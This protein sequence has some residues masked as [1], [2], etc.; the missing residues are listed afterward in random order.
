MT[1]PVRSRRARAVVFAYHN[2]GVHCLYSLLAHDV[3]VALVVT[4]PDDPNENQWF[5]SVGELAKEHHLP[6]LYVEDAQ[7][8]QL[9][10][11]ILAIAPDFIF[12]FY[13]RRMLPTALLA[14]ATRGALNMHG[15][16]LP[17]YR[18]RA[19]VNWAVIHGETETGATLHY[20]T[21]KPDAGDIVGQERV[22]ILPDETAGEVFD[23]VTFAAQALMQRVLPDLLKGT[24][25]AQAQ[26]LSQG[27][28]FGGRRPEDGQIDWSADAH[29]IHNLVRGVAPPYPGAFTEVRGLHLRVLRTRLEPQSSPATD[30]PALYVQGDACFV[31][32]LQGGR[33]RLLDLEIDGKSANAAQFALR[34][35]S[36]RIALGSAP[37]DKANTIPSFIQ[38]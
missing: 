21:A 15:A 35:G 12:S 38:T 2:V 25:Q 3:E 33:L 23:K 22:T 31:D 8:A 26:D 16:L 29:T 19:P 27:S 36:E 7:S 32:C 9:R 17:K 11:Q 13:F 30:A 28:Y 34:F 6:V 1:D 37:T 14:L 5:A 24:A 20:M 4:H 18:G 10:A